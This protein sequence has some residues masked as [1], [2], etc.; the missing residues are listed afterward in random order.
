MNIN[1]NFLFKKNTSRYKDSNQYDNHLS[2][3]HSRIQ[4]KGGYFVLKI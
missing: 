1:R 3:S 2:I 4:S